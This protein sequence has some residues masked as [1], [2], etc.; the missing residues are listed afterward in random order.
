MLLFSKLHCAVAM[1]IEDNCVLSFHNTSHC[2]VPF[3]S[4]IFHLIVYHNHPLGLQYKTAYAS[5]AVLQI[6]NNGQ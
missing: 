1:E 3:S 4:G 2:F 5:F 6:K